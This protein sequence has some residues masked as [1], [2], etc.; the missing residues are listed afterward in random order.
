MENNSDQNR[1][2]ECD[3]NC[4]P[5]K[6]SNIFS[7]AIFGLVI[8][9]AV[10]IIVVKIFFQPV[11]GADKQIVN[12]QGSTSCCDTSSGK[13]SDTIKMPSCCPRTK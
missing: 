12:K 6:K 11:S 1:D 3:G 10:V 8:L 13:T 9:A 2:C 7:K 4:C 5:P